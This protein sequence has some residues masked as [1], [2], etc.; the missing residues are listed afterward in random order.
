MK[1]FREDF[2]PEWQQWDGKTGYA[3]S[4]QGGWGGGVKP[5]FV[6]GATD[7]YGWFAQDDKMHIHDLHA[8]MLHLPGIEHTK[9]TYNYAGRPFR[10]TDVHGEVAHKIIA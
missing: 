4:S 2:L 10:L 7:N 5:G 1:K 6:Y 9:L 3:F 8:T